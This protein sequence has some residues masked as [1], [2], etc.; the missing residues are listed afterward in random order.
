MTL[1]LKDNIRVEI[2]HDEKATNPRDE[3]NLG[4]MVC[5]DNKHNLGDKH[6]FETVDDFKKFLRKKNRVV[7]VYTIYLYEYKEILLSVN[8]F[9]HPYKSELIGYIYTTKEMAR[10]FYNVKIF[11]RELSKTIRDVLLEEIKAYN[12][13]LNNEVYRYTIYKDD[14]IIDTRGNIYG[15]N[16][17]SK[18]RELIKKEHKI[19][20]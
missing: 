19:Y 17:L 7:F 4:M 12:G 18:I 6:N 9:S 15:S 5:W 16:Y 8:E 14:E 13:Y 1:T 11:S 20:I 3:K 2:T 10:D